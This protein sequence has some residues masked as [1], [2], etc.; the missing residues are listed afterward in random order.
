TA[1]FEVSEPRVP[2][3]RLAVRMNDP[4][5][6]RRFTDALRPGAYLRIIVEGD[7]SGGDEIRVV[8]KP[9]HDLTIRE[10]FRIYTRDRNEIERLVSI[11]RMSERWRKWAEGLLQ[12]ELA[13]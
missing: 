10:V 1:L 7:L 12:K 13:P 11:P 9:S 8:E 3:W 5:S 6:P 4:M 2:C